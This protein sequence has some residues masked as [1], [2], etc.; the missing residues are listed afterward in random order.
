MRIP[1]DAVIPAEKLNQYLLIPRPWD[2]KSEFLARAGFSLADSAALGR[3]IRSLAGSVDA[4]EDGQNEYGTFFRVEG[5]LAGPNGRPLLVVLIWLQW[6]ID[7]TFHLVT[8]KPQSK[9]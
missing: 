1:P 2:D 5:E 7:G 8:L 3:A 4:F 6:N 9:K